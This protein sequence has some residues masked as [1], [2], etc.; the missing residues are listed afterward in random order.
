MAI[1]EPDEAT[2]KFVAEQEKLMEVGE[3]IIKTASDEALEYIKDAVENLNDRQWRKMVMST[4]IVEMGVGVGI[5][6]HLVPQIYNEMEKKLHKQLK[7]PKETSRALRHIYIGR[8]IK[9]V[10]RALN[11]RDK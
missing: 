9:N 1:Q 4:Q 7:L 5:A 10:R 3:G 11:E 6:E 2:L 8:V